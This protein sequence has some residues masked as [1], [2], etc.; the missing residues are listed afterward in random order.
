MK[1]QLLPALSEV[2]AK[3]HDDFAKKDKVVVIGYFDG[4]EGK[5]YQLFKTVANKFRDDFLFGAAVDKKLAKDKKVKG[6][7]P[8]IV[9]YKQFDEKK[10]VFPEN[11][12]EG[13][14]LTE[15]NLAKFISVNSVPL[16]N[17]IGPDNYG[18][19][20]ESG[21]PLFYLFVD[22]P[23]NRKEAGAQVEPVAKKY[24]GKVNFVYI[25]AGQFGGHAKNL[26]LKEDWPA[27]AIEEPSKHTKFPFDQ[28]KEI[29]EENV[30]AFVAEY[31]AGKIKPS[32][33]SA[34]IPEEN[35]G[36]V[37]VVV[38]DNFKDLVMDKEKDVLVEFYAPWCGHCK[39][40]SSVPGFCL[41]YC[42]HSLRF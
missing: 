34:P 29:T 17:D 40:C 15:E 6:D 7:L 10:N 23:E 28:T 12:E 9:L 13:A 26:N 24:R 19:Y 37:K 32:V 42:I 21:L 3:N 18:K 1:K 2:T 33:K 35:D 31:L 22:T 11:V 8:A 39:V 16:M 25:D 38:A 20:V 4:T 14:E 27:A 5:E 36:P 41:N 30:D